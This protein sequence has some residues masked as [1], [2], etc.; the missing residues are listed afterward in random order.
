MSLLNVSEV[1]MSP[2][3]MQKVKVYRKYNGRWQLGKFIEDEVVLQL[4]MLVCPSSGRDIMRIPEADRVEDS[5]TF[6][7]LSKLYLTE[8]LS[9]LGGSEVRTSD[10]VEWNCQKYK[11]V[12]V[13]DYSDYGYYRAVG[14]RVRGY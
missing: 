13:P 7:C 3:F 10:I 12:S 6:H 11:I 4:D 1:L 8:D 2:E 14:V 5:R 9:E